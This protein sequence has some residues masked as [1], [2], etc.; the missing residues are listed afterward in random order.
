VRAAGAALVT[1]ASRGLGRALA[2]ELARRGFDVVATLRQPERGGSLADAARRDGLTLRVESLDVTRPE[3]IRIPDGLRLLVNNAGIEGAWLP[4]E[5]APPSLWRE[6]FETNLFGLLEVTRRAIPSLRAAGGG[7]I[8]NVTS[9][10]MLAPMPLFAAYR[11]SKA[12][13]SALGESLRTELSAFG[14]RIVE[15]QPGAIATDM[16]AGITDPPEAITSPGYEDLAK[17][18]H[19]ARAPAA[20]SATPPADAARA[21]VDVILD[22]TAPLRN[23]CDPM[24][25]RLLEAWRR[26]DDEEMMRGMVKLF[27]AKTP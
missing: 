13:V 18:V 27:A 4:V 15:V 9:C 7:V 16:L 20:R 21:I 8:C 23:A 10:A 19:V 3:T 12:A 17:W 2:F 14:I 22:D 24:G 1:G 6:V 25:A 11:A 5:H 26:S